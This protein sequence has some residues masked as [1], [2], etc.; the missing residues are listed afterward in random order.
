VVTELEDP[1]HAWVAVAKRDTGLRKIATLTRRAFVGAVAATGVFA[2]IAAHSFAGRTSGV[3]TTGPATSSP[4]DSGNQPAVQP[5]SDDTQPYYLQPPD[6][7]P[8]PSYGS[9]HVRSGGS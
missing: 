6:Q 5:P 9:G 4:T 3:T 7:V 8:Q 1:R 2:G